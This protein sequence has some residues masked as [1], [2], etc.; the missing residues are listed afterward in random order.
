MQRRNKRAQEIACL[1]R[2]PHEQVM[3]GIR[4]L[5]L[6]MRCIMALVLGLCM[7]A[8][9]GAGIAVNA[10]KPFVIGCFALSAIVVLMGLRDHI[11]AS[12]LDDQIWQ[13]RFSSA[14]RGTTEVKSLDALSK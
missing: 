13:A 10:S 3:A 11:E 4:V 2:D 7:G 14:G 5:D 1:H 8:L 6:R 12:M 9:A